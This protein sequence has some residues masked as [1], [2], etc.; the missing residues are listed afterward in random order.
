VIGTVVLLTFNAAEYLFPFYAVSGNLFLGFFVLLKN[1]RNKVNVSYS[2]TAIL[3]ALWAL[4]I[5]FLSEARTIPDAM[6]CA[7]I[8][9]AFYAYFPLPFLYFFSVFP[10]EDVVPRT[11]QMIA[12]FIVA[13][14]FALISF[15]DLIVRDMVLV[16]DRF[17]MVAGAAFSL[18]IFYY[19]GFIFFAFYRLADKFNSYKG[20]NKRQIAYVLS[21][22]FIGVIFPVV[23]NLILPLFGY[24]YLTGVGPFSTIITTLLIAFA[25]TK[26]RLM[27]ISVIISRLLA[28]IMTLFFHAAI[29]LALVWVYRGYFHRVDWIFVLGTVAYGFF[30]GLTHHPIRLLVQTTADKL[31]IK[32]KYNYTKSMA[33]ATT[34]VAEK[35]SMPSVLGILFRTFKEVMEIQTPR[36]LLPNNFLAGDKPSTDYVEYDRATFTPLGGGPKIPLD[37]PLIAKLTEKRQPIV[38]HHGDWE[39]VVPCMLENRVVGLFLLGKKLSEDPYTD[40]DLRLLEVLASQA[41]ITFDHTRSYEKIRL[42]FDEN[43][44]KL[45]D[46][47]RLLARS[48]RIA[49]LANLI[50]EYNHEIKTPLAIMRSELELLSDDP[51]EVKDFKGFKDEMIKEIER[52]DDIVISTLRLSEPKKRQD[53]PLDLNEVINNALKL[54]PPSGVH[55]VKELG[56]V[57]KLVGDPDDLQMVFINLVKNALE[58]MPKGGNLTIST[59][60]VEKEGAKA[61][62]AK[63]A[64]SGAGIAKENLEKIF[65]PFFST[66]VTKGRG[67]G[68]SIVFR[69]VREHNAT[70]DVESEV[71][72][73]TT[74]IM[75]F[76]LL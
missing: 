36:I 19:L 65:E 10:Q 57:P 50:R 62:V 47:E 27:D 53:I 42:D 26:S 64:D 3:T 75:T 23:T 46:T 71:G 13:T 28:E 52:A 72:K 44:K 48:E 8:A 74:F 55:F 35:L 16:N 54:M 14:F 2:L 76:P 32:G 58:A 7:K 67:L 25:I 61:V 5:F 45:Y 43:Q 63:V 4:S 24:P 31:F 68:L 6:L 34:R 12:W 1:W 41:A 51:K 40:E 11:Y 21:G 9:A 33:E 66:H 22:F 18:F 29:Y 70:I 59:A 17:V 56:A 39:V 60:L 37:D 20:L 73:G 30:V 49:S 15:S 69:V 38:D